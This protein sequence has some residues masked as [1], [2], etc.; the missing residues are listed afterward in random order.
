MSAVGCLSAGDDT[1]SRST[2]T[3]DAAGLDGHSFGGEAWW[4]A[5]VGR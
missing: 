3:G 1:L 4:D 2:D 5:T